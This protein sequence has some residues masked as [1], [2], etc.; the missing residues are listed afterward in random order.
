MR[1]NEMRRKLTQD[2][3]DFFRLALL[4][5]RVKDDDVFTLHPKKK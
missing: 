4:D 2:G 1:E 3:F 5:E